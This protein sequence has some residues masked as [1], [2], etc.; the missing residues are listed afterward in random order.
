LSFP[1]WW[2]LPPLLLL[3]PVINSALKITMALA[4]APNLAVPVKTAA[5]AAIALNVAALA[6]CVS[7]FV[8]CFQIFQKFKCFK[9]KVPRP[10]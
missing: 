2:L 4:Q 3:F 9:Q 10:G 5:L 8:I 1:P 6:A 7:K